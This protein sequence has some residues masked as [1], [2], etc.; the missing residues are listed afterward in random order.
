M[1]YLNPEFENQKPYPL[2][3]NRAR[4]VW[5]LCW[6]IPVCYQKKKDWNTNGDC[7]NTMIEVS[8]LKNKHQ[9]RQLKRPKC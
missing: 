3:N 2:E 7:K 5:F 8:Y 6:D 1:F 9:T 4:V